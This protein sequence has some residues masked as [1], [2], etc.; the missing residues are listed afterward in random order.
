MWWNKNA[1]LSKF[2]PAALNILEWFYFVTSLGKR[3]CY[4]MIHYTEQMSLLSIITMYK[5]WGKLVF[6]Y[7]LIARMCN[8]FTCNVKNRKFMVLTEDDI[9]FIHAT[10][11]PKSS[12]TSTTGHMCAAVV[13]VHESMK[14]VE[15]EED[16]TKNHRNVRV[17]MEDDTVRHCQ[18]GID[19]QQHLGFAS[20]ESGNYY[21][22]GF[23]QH[24]PLQFKEFNLSNVE[25]VL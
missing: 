18:G 11:H 21:C 16:V 5:M 10:H 3:L 15:L 19:I 14:A 7:I 12:V 17:T 1:S 8:V 25:K 22:Q 6:L 2:K 4:C 13:Y 24:L 20:V 9:H 23:L